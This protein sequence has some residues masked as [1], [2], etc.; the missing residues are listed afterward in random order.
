MRFP[1]RLPTAAAHS[2]EILRFGE[3]RIIGQKREKLS[4]FCVFRGHLGALSPVLTD[5]ENS[6]IASADRILLNGSPFLPTNLFRR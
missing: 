4:R 3:S 6:E 5:P 1:A 2:R